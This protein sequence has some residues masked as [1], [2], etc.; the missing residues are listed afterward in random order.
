MQILFI[1]L[2]FS[3]S[4]TDKRNLKII[5]AEKHIYQSEKPYIY[6]KKQHTLMFVP[7]DNYFKNIC[8]ISTMPA[9]HT[10]KKERCG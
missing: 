3:L 5:S 9:R 10:D 7:Y 4:M 1:G 2:I 8:N 6:I